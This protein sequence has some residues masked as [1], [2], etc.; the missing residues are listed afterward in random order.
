MASAWFP[1]KAFYAETDSRL[2]SFTFPEVRSD[3]GSVVFC[4]SSTK[5]KEQCNLLVFFDI[6]HQVSEI[7]ILRQ[8]FRTGFSE[9]DSGL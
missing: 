4:L 1:H 7:L 9:L 8:S 2:N 5:V 3:D 6:Y